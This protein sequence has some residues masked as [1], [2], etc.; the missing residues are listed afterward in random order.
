MQQHRVA[1]ARARAM[2]RSGAEAVP[3][4]PSVFVVLFA[5]PVTSTRRSA[6][7]QQF[8]KP[9]APATGRLRLQR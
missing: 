1:T 6:P 7:H 2:V 8:E 4:A 5:V 3:F 9:A